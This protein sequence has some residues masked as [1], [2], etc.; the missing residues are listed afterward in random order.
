MA[1]REWT[2]EEESLLRAGYRGRFDA[3]LCRRLGRSGPAVQQR[4][5]LLGL[6]RDRLPSPAWSPALE[7]EYRLL[8]AEGLSDNDIAARWGCCRVWLNGRRKALGLPSNRSNRIRQ[9]SRENLRYQLER[10]G[11]PTFADLRHARTRRLVARFGLPE[12]LP[13]RALRIVL[14]LLSGPKT[15]SQICAALDLARVSET[16]FRGR[17]RSYLSILRD[18]GLVAAL[19]LPGR[20]A[21]RKVYS[22]TPRC[23]DL[24]SAT[25]KE[26]V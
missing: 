6:C 7:T 24:L 21:D 3:A 9:K 13:P 16:A 15:R 10:E 26:A 14:A 18:A 8:H 20:G 25:A 22:L 1:G 11:L 5:K 2:A 4:A 23:L 19:R 17:R 12:D